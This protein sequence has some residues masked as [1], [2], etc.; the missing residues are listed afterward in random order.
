MTEQLESPIEKIIE[1][2]HINH[3]EKKLDKRKNVRLAKIK[4]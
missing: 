3:I 1:R 4:T 2:G